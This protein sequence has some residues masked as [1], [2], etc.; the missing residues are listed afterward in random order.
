MGIHQNLQTNHSAAETEGGKANSL[1]GRH[2]I[3]RRVE[4]NDSQSPGRGDTSVGKSGFHNQQEEIG[5]E[6][7]SNPGIPKSNCRLHG[8]GAMLPPIGM[9]SVY[10]W[11]PAK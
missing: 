2:T 3:A 8:N 1:H 9:K 11:R 6:P 7:S 5:H 4:R 10:G